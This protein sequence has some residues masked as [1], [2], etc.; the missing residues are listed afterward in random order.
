[1]VADNNSNDRTNELARK[2]GAKVVSE[3]RQGY[4]YACRAAMGNA[5]GDIIILVESDGTFSSK[6]IIKFL[7]YSEDFD[8]ILGTRTTKELIWKGSNMG[9]F[10]RWGN[11][12]L[13]KIVEFL[14]NGPHLSDVGCTYRLIKREALEEIQ[15]GFSVGGS[16]FSPEMMILALKKRIRMLE[17]PVNYMPRIGESK[18][19]GEKK[20]AFKVGLRMIW[21]M[22]SYKAHS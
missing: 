8:F 6:D 10:L 15:P 9:S 13:A 5:T 17:I 14:Y 20:K 21:F 22:I 1:V 19:T 11:W 2:A 18:I 12:F 7:A 4:G 16:H 3:R